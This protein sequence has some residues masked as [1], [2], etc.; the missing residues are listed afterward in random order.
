[1]FEIPY[2]V[3]VIAT[4]VI[5]GLGILCLLLSIIIMVKATMSKSIHAIAEQTT[6]LAEKGITDNVSGLVGNASALISS[7]NDLAR[8]NTGIGI[9]MV[10]LAMTLL[11]AAYFLAKQLGIGLPI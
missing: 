9:F 1:M 2:Q 10:F 4:A 3:F 5:G 11:A 8:S 6:K 7:L